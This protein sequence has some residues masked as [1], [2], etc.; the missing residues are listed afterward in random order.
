LTTTP[1]FELPDAEEREALLGALADVCARC[2]GEPLR[3]RPLEPD[4]RWFPDPWDGTVAGAEALARRLLAYAALPLDAVVEDGPPEGAEDEGDAV[5]WFCG[6]GHGRAWFALAPTLLTDPEGA[7]GS[8]AHEVAH[9]FRNHHG[10]CDPD[11]G[12]EELLTDATT[13][14]LGFG[15][16][17][18][19]DTWRFQTRSASG[20]RRHPALGYLS[21]GSMAFLLAAQV[22]AQGARGGA[23]R[24][25]ARLLETNQAQAFRAACRLLARDA[26]ALRRRL[27][28]A[29]NVR[30]QERPV[31][32]AMLA[33]GAGAAGARREE[34]P[35]NSGTSVF[36]V[37]RSPL[38]AFGSGFGAAL[39]TL[40]VLGV[41]VGIAARDLPAIAARL[42]DLL[43][44]VAIASCIVGLA[45]GA[46]QLRKGGYDCSDPACPGAPGARDAFCPACHGEIAGTIRDRNDRL[47]AEEALSGEVGPG[48]EDGGVGPGG[49][50]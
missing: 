40:L 20:A 23:R 41:P 7:A 24:R 35:D 26:P 28:L 13:V 46:R 18:V 32:S 36:R 33:P 45:V 42:A 6:I 25:V 3:T 43:W 12:R 39:A 44:G 27:G 8:L 11:P 2:G 47:A 30:P 19:N 31:P 10:L 48:P 15:I 37:R 5:A 29:A 21:P 9:A 22:V 16:L 14:Y 34:G 1:G 38:N 49:T 4:A 50:R 17:T